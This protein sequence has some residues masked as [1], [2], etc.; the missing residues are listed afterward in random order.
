MTAGGFDFAPVLTGET[1]QLRPL[2]AADREALYRAAA[3]P[4]IWAGHPAKT[5]HERAVF[6]PYFDFLLASGGTL[7]VT[8]REDGRVI[9]AS[10]FY[11]VA[12][13]PGSVAIG[14]TFLARAHWGGPANREMKALMLAHGFRWHDAVWLDIGTDNLR[15]QRAAEKIGAECMG[16]AELTLGR[17]AA[18]YVCYRIRRA[19]WQG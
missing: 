4:L 17:G 16:T 14:F 15:S 6:D 9:G 8:L 1:L 10:R 13:R 5:R 7:T 11:E 19:D 12:E 3:D 18:E 2:V